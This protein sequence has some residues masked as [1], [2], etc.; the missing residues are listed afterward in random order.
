[1][2]SFLSTTHKTYGAETTAAIRRI[3]LDLLGSPDPYYVQ[4]PTSSNSIKTA[5]SFVSLHKLSIRATCGGFSSFLRLWA[6]CFAKSTFGQP[7]KVTVKWL[8]PREKRRTT[9]ELYNFASRVRLL[10]RISLEDGQQVGYEGI[11]AIQALRWQRDIGHKPILAPTK[12]HLQNQEEN[13][14]GWKSTLSSTM[15]PHTTACAP[16]AERRKRKRRK[17]DTGPCEMEPCAGRIRGSVW[18]EPPQYP[19][20]RA[21]AAT[22]A[23]DRMERVASDQPLG[24]GH[25]D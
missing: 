1:M 15:G 6:D 12:H 21:Q 9:T 14:R 22:N 5:L 3:E 18:S 11:T 25:S 4:S 17:R 7:K 19:R 8:V 10:R 16:G 2:L 20:S 13:P 23:A 24:R